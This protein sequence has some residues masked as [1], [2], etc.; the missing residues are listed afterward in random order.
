MLNAVTLPSE[1]W[2]LPA[3]LLSVATQKTTTQERGK[4]TSPLFIVLHLVVNSLIKNTP[5]IILCI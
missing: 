3:I 5:C 4:F 2:Y 1:G